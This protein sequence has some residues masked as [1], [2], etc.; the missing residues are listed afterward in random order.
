MLFSFTQLKNLMMEKDSETSLRIQ[1]IK[2]LMG[3]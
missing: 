3:E 2:S 1:K